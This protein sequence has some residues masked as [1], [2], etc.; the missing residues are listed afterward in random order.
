MMLG[1]VSTASALERVQ[2]RTRVGGLELTEQHSDVVCI[3][4]NDRHEF[5]RSDARVDITWL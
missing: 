4:V 5:V 3:Y 1:A 2:T